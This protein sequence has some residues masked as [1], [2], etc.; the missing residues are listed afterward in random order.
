MKLVQTCGA[1]PEQYD[2]L[3]DAGKTVGY[4]RLRWS[5]FTADYLPTGDLNGDEELVYEATIDD[6]G[7]SGAF[8]T[9]EQR[10]EH[11]TRALAAIA[12]RMVRP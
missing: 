7:L 4:L 10:R 3:D 12:E 8:S 11:L 9:E 2:V 1:C 6:S 5:C